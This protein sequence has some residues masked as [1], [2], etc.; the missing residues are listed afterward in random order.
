MRKKDYIDEVEIAVVIILVILVGLV[1]WFGVIPN[2]GNNAEKKA[3]ELSSG[4]YK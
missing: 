3:I 4:I 1:S 2:I